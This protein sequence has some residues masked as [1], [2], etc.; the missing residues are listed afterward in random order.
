MALYVFSFLSG[1]I[2]VQQFVQLPDDRCLIA[3][4]AIAVFSAYLRYWRWLFFA[5]G[6]IWAVLFA[7]YRLA[8][9]L[10]APLEGIDISVEGYI[11]DLPKQDEKYSRFQFV[12]TESSKKLPAKVRLSWYQPDRPV[13]AGQRWSMTVRL[14]RPHGNVNPGGFDYERWLFVEGLG[15]TGY[16]RNYPKPEFLG[17]NTA[18]FSVDR[19]RQAI[20]DRLDELSLDASSLAL[21]KALTIG[22]SS[23]ISQRQW[24][25]FRNS[26]TVHLFVISGAHIGLVAGLVY[27]LMLRLWAWTGILAWP[28]QKV[29]AVAS[30]LAGVFYSALA[31]FSVPAQRAVIM[32]TI[33]MSAIFLQRHTRPFNV[34]SMALCAILLYDP[35]A[36]LSPGFWL[37][38]L[39][40]ATIIYVIAGRLAKPGYVAGV[41]KIN[42]ATAVAL[43]PLLLYFF[44]QVS[45]ISPVAN[46]IAVPV[47]SLLAV[48]L[49]LLSVLL[50]FLFPLAADW[51]LIIVDRIL[52]GLCWLLGF[53]SGLPMAMITHPAPPLWV[54]LF[55]V[56]GV[57]IL[58]A[59]R[60]VPGRWLGGVLFLP[61][62]FLNKNHPASGEIAMTMLDVGQGLSTVV[63]TAHHLLVFDAGAK[64]GDSDMGERVVVP[65]LLHQGLNKIDKLI[66]SHGDNDHIGGADSLMQAMPTDSV[67][68]SVVEPLAAHKPIACSAGQSWS[69][70][71]VR[72]TVLSPPPK[73][74][75]SDNNNS[76]V[77]QIQSTRGTVL[78]TGDIES[79]TETWLVANY[80]DKLNAEILIAPHHGSK[81][82]S[83]VPFLKTVQPRYVLISSGFRNQFGHPHQQVISRY[84]QFNAHWLNTAG[85]GAIS[86]SSESDSWRVSTER[87]RERR[88]WRYP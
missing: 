39:A 10:P 45:L 58:L 21:V 69:W 70:D 31:G 44:Q 79:E 15:A 35:I 54:L 83:T 7:S 87:K 85:S 60:G 42:W 71:N 3:V 86:L 47:I 75:F 38:F 12:I 22:D 76:C 84:E 52:Q 57:L 74:F 88:Y 13:K 18:W 34:L 30:L 11:S 64:F 20:V 2:V 62:L 40:V 9:R 16:V 59:P 36:V 67:L 56:P 81:T 28:P 43:S 29:A 17:W 25:L 4:A 41:A 66:V 51:L 77:L 27:F 80:Q 8:D 23:T 82:S 37:S 32:L 49:S 78:L 26:G 65:F 55:A 24:R 5:I 63:Q 73:K 72:F 14:K 68:T 6:V 46:F 1:I 33:V 19:W 61:L 53:L 50:L 48:P